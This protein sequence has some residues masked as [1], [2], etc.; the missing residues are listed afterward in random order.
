MQG[1]S[2]EMV[3]LRWVIIDGG[4]KLVQQRPTATDALEYANE[5]LADKEEMSCCKSDMRVMGMKNVVDLV[6]T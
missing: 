6:C 2:K 5:R 4:S 3:E 1:G